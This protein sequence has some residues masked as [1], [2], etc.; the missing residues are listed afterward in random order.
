[1][2]FVF[3]HAPLDV[4]DAPKYSRLPPGSASIQLLCTFCCVFL[5]GS[6][7]NSR[8]I[9]SLHIELSQFRSQI[10]LGQE[11]R[12]LAPQQFPETYTI[13]IEQTHAESST[14]RIMNDKKCIINPKNSEE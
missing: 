5:G 13:D 6:V 11:Y 14:L 1:M 9:Q 10:I 3:L 7:S 12:V 8:S 2:I 4:Y